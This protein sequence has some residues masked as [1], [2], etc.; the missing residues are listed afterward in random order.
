ML[1]LAIAA[2]AAFLVAPALAETAQKLVPQ[3]LA[4][5]HLSFAPVVKKAQP[6]VVN[7]YASRVEQRPQNPLFDDPIFR[8]FFGNQGE[9]ARTAQSLG[10]GVIVD[11]SGLIVTNHHVIEGMTDV[12]VA[13][14][15]HREF[16]AQIVLRDPRTDLAVL[17]IKGRRNIPRARAWR[18]RRD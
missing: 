16:E 10:S 7:V 6:A 13:L 5:V 1:R 17:K 12:K 3:T 2:L 4:E 15:D 14:S 8:R 18:F 9:N 11:P